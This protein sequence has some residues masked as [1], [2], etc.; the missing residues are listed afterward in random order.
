M[1]KLFLYL[2]MYVL[3]FVA[4]Y[5][6]SFDFAKKDMEGKSIHGTAS[7]E[8]SENSGD[9]NAK[10]ETENA[11]EGETPER[12][13]NASANPNKSDGQDVLVSHAASDKYI[14]GLKNNYVIVYKND[15]SMVYEYTDIDGSVIKANDNEA[16]KMLLRS[17]EF[18]DKEEMFTFLESLSS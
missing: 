17:V 1:K 5:N 10:N 15:K 7:E 9:E 16:Y 18:E 13:N 4:A 11:A 12:L 2:I 8:H 3:L 14:V 6:V